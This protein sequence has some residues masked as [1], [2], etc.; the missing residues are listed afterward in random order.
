MSTSIVFSWGDIV[1]FCLRWV[2]IGVFKA[3][4]DLILLEVVIER[5]LGDVGD[6]LTQKKKP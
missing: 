4:E 5:F 2:E 1:P 6:N 3:S